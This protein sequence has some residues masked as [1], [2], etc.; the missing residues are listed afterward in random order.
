MS[1]P[2]VG[3]N[4][5]PIQQVP[6]APFLGLNS[7][8]MKLITHLHLVPRLGMS[9][10]VLTTSHICPRRIDRDNFTSLPSYSVNKLPDAHWNGIA[11]VWIQWHMFILLLLVMQDITGLPENNN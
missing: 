2:A 4:Q 3:P 10:V 8:G 11:E 6:G 5:P 1:R 7:Q 9:G